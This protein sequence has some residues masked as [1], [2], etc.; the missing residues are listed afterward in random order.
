MRTLIRA[1]KTAALLL[2]LCLMSAAAA[3]LATY[4]SLTKKHAV[5]YS[6]F[7]HTIA[8]LDLTLD[9][10]KRSLIVLQAQFDDLKK[11]ADIRRTVGL[12]P[13]DVPADHCALAFVEQRG[14]GIKKQ[15][16]LRK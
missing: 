13:L 8:T 14:N 6:E 10:N 1:L 5:I 9:T 3:T 4:R 12:A 2:L 11:V 7:K 15:G 16:G